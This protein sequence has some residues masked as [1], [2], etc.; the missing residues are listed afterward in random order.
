M[1]RQY[2]EFA[3]FY[4]SAAWN[5]V[6]LGL[7][8]YE[9]NGVPQNYKRAVKERCKAAEAGNAG[10][11]FWFGLC[12]EEG[13]G[14]P[15]NYRKAEYWFRK[16]AAAGSAEAKNKLGLC[17]GNGEGGLQDS[18]DVAKG[19]SSSKNQCKPTPTD[20]RNRSDAAVLPP[21]PSDP[22]ADKEAVK[23]KFRTIFLALTRA[24][25][26]LNDEVKT[27]NRLLDGVK[28]E[29]GNVLD[30][31]FDDAL[32]KMNEAINEMPWDR[33]GIAFFGETTAGK[34]TLVE[35]FRTLFERNRP[36]GN[37]GLII[38]DM[39]P[40]FTQKST[41][42]EMEIDG[43]PFVLVDAP[44]T[45][46]DV[47]KFRPEIEKSLRRVHCVFYVKKGKGV[48]ESTVAEN[49]GT[50]LRDCADVYSI[51]NVPGFDYEGEDDRKTLLSDAVRE[52]GRLIGEGLRKI[53][54]PDAYKGNIPVQGLIALCAHAE[55]ASKRQDLKENQCYFRE[56]F[57]N[58]DAMWKFS[59]AQALVDLV[60][61]L[62]KPENFTV[63]INAANE[64]RLKSLVREVRA[65]VEKFLKE[66]EETLALC[67][68]A[69][70]ELRRNSDKMKKIIS[71]MSDE[72]A[73]GM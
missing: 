23:K 25:M 58:A 29:L 3:E 32:A 55:F 68:A 27:K 2:E 31:K 36:R 63:E 54:N 16:A 67:A 10:A 73:A 26:R 43:R 47:K 24:S 60:K 19:K 49:I 69:D 22:A 6:N 18:A 62:A 59:N 46:G 12:Y 44:G 65:D 1:N 64:R 5:V 48:F 37:D 72:L 9:G 30:K 45:E 7:C 34:S 4:R 14:V 20:N 52:D 21:R 42:Y 33:L 11:M 38:G 50:Y 39:S 61:E 53:L 35:M 40:D 51:Q 17:R 15:Q 57:G 56:R 71:R 41:E 13:N 28:T 8:C 66:K 70:G